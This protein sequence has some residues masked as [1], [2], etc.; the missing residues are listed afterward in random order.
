MKI[1][2]IALL[3]LSALN[4]YAGY[5][6]PDSPL[7]REIQKNKE[8]IKSEDLSS[9]EGLH[10]IVE[11]FKYRILKATEPV[12]FHSGKRIKA[13]TEFIEWHLLRP[14]FRYY[15]QNPTKSNLSEFIDVC[16]KWHCRTNL[17]IILKLATY[18]RL[19]EE[20]EEA[21]FGVVDLDW[22][23]RDLKAA[24]ETEYSYYLEVLESPRILGVLAGDELSKTEIK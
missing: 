9:E 16:E 20:L 18:N 17:D 12:D 7:P 5:F 14:L 3:L 24:A 13:K 22:A 4:L 10:L 1:P 19:K 8:L 15:E 21:S 6:D 11:E 2:H 23:L